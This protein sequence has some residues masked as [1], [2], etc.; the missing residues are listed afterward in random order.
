MAI[1]KGNVPRSLCYAAAVLAAA[2][3]RAEGEV[4]HQV[5]NWSVPASA[6]GLVIDLEHLQPSIVAGSAAPW[7]VRMF[8]ES[9][10]EFAAQDGGGVTGL[11]RYS[12]DPT[13]S[14]P[15]SLPV[16]LAVGP[17]SQ[18]GS[19][20][21]S[22]GGAVGQWRLNDANYFGFRFVSRE[23]DVH[24]GWGRIGIG[25]DAASRTVVEIAWQDTPGL[26]MQVGHTPAAGPLVLM[27]IAA[28]VGGPRRARPS[29]ASC[30]ASSL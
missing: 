18:F 13:M 7:Q 12:L 17:F 30:G 27:G 22:F 25:A 10:L 6:D 14:G 23:G 28:L 20:S 24:F 1:V 9:G 19:G 11:M 16:D 4:V 8:G 15:G 21:A 26:G 5:L 2:L 3:E 29:R